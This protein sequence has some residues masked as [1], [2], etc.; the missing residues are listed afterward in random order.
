MIVNGPV[1]DEIE[2]E[3]GQA[4]FGPGFRANATIGLRIAAGDPQRVP[5]GARCARSASFSWPLRYSFCFGE[6]E[7][8]SDWTPLHVQLGYERTQSVVT[9]ESI[10]DFFPVTEFEPEPE[11]ILDAVV[12][13]ARNRG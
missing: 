10:L 9:I 11:E 4:C 3:S 8:S 12:V 2:V 5:G 13:M 1:R 6:N 7:E